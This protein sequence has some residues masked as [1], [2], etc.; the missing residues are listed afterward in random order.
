MYLS[1]AQTF[2]AGTASLGVTSPSTSWFF[3]EGAT[4]PFFELFLLLA[5]PGAGCGSGNLRYT[6][7]AGLDLTK[8]YTLPPRSRHTICVDEETFPGLGTALA[9]AAVSARV[10]ASAPIVAEPAMWWPGG[11]AWQED[12]GSPGATAAA[13]RWI[14]AD[15][16][17]MGPRTVQTYVLIANT[18]DSDATV[19]VTVVPEAGTP[20]AR[21]FTVPAN[22]R[23]TVD[24]GATFTTLYTNR[25]RRG[26]T[27]RR[28]RREPRRHGT[29]CK[30]LQIQTHVGTSLIST[31]ARL[32]PTVGGSPVD[33]SAE[34][35]A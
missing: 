33:A 10:S 6:T 16:G 31:S 25:S 30:F 7:D 15:G 22:R 24:I 34:R 13:T 12:H 29:A 20:N 27:D 3:A 5:N 4:G 17:I 2:Q 21:E 18:S 1:G 14:L 8:S 9:N 26:R 28:H 23:F 32:L 19:R 11:Q 35:D